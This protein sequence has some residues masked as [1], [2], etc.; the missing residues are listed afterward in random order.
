MQTLLVLV[1]RLFSERLPLPEAA[2]QQYVDGY[3]DGDPSFGELLRR[4]QSDLNL[5][6]LGPS[7]ACFV[8]DESYARLLGGAIVDAFADRASPS[9]G[10]LHEC[11][12]IYE[13]ASI[14]GIVEVA[15]I[16]EKL[17]PCESYL[18]LLSTVRLLRSPNVYWKGATIG[19]FQRYSEFLAGRS[20]ESGGRSPEKVRRAQQRLHNRLLCL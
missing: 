13:M 6:P 18:V 17:S 10:F 12:R 16:Y 15:S 7:T 14:E 2:I 20:Q 3:A 1:E 8:L 9:I 11:F 19:A 5:G 4:G